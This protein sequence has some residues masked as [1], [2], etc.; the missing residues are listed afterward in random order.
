MKDFIENISEHFSRILDLMNCETILVRG[1]NAEYN[2]ED[3]K[4]WLFNKFVYEKTT[5]NQYDW[6][7]KSCQFRS[8][9]RKYKYDYQL[10]VD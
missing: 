3:V 5:F 7:P 4:S 10:D 2:T 1:S 9:I 6:Q 8:I